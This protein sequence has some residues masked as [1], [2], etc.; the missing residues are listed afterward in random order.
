MMTGLRE[1]ARFFQAGLCLW[2][3]C[4]GRPSALA[5]QKHHLDCWQVPSLDRDET[6]H[7]GVYTTFCGNAC[8]VFTNKYDL[9]EKSHMLK[10]SE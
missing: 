5:L 7:F 8:I 9:G 3:R 6:R 4:S 10:T 2:N 1:L